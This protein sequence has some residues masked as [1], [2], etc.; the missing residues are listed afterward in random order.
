MRRPSRIEQVSECPD[1]IGALCDSCEADLE[2]VNAVREEKEELKMFVQSRR[3]AAEGLRVPIG[4][5]APEMISR[6]QDP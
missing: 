5:C 3:E 6:G 1:D 4:F 2:R